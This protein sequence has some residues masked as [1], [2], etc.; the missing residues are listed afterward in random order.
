MLLAERALLKAL[1]GVGVQH[2]LQYQGDDDVGRYRQRDDDGE[3][4]RVEI[5]AGDQQQR[6]HH[7]EPSSQ[8]LAGDELA[9]AVEFPHARHRLTGRP[10]LEVGD[11]Q[12]EEMAEYTG[13]KLDIDAARRVGEKMGAEIFRHRLEDDQQHHGDDDGDQRC[14]AVVD[15][16]L[17]DDNLEQQ[18]RRQPEQLDDQ[19]GGENEG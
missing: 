15:Q 16:H 19:R 10:R 7:V 12:L 2:G 11:G 6:E 3:R 1:L 17:V 4:R 8:R 18:R 5:E 13:A 14:P 9:D